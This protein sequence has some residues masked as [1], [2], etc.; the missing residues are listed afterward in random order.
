ARDNKIP[1]YMVRT[2]YDME[3]GKVADDRLWQPAILRTGGRFYAASDEATILRALEDID[4]LSPGR[5]DLKQY[6]VQRPRFSAY[7]L[8][9]IG[10]WFLAGVLKL[11]VPYFRTFP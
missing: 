1:I 4:K 2:A 6:S 3:L 11:S 8:V 5:I 10:L 9:A 7:A